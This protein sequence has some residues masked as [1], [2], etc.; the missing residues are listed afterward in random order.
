M[1][2]LVLGTV[3]GLFLFLARDRLEALWSRVSLP[4]S[5]AKAPSL[6]TLAVTSE[7]YE[8]VQIAPCEG[9]ACRAKV[10]E[11]PTSS[12]VLIEQ[13]G[14]TPG[15]ATLLK[16]SR[17]GAVLDK[18]ELEPDTRLGGSGLLFSKETYVDW[19]WT[20]DKTPKPYLEKL[21][22]NALAPEALEP[23]L[24]EA[25]WLDCEVDHDEQT[26]RCF[27][28]EP[29]QKGGGVRLLR[30][31]RHYH[32]L[33]FR[34]DGDFPHY[35][36]RGHESLSEP[37]L[38]Q[39]PAENAPGSPRAGRALLLR[40]LVKQARL[41]PAPMDPTG[42]RDGWYGIGFWDLMHRGERLAFRAPAF[43]SARAERVEPMFDVYVV[44]ATDKEPPLPV[45]V[46]AGGEV[47]GGPPTNLGIW[48]V[49]SRT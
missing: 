36:L 43:G 11:L 20:G 49:R 26:G 29:A 35:V 5:Q 48:T 15:A 9:P 31:Q 18:C 33:T 10:F 30:T 28:G 37:K 40:H 14:L 38:R 47:K 13:T 8:L 17:A 6:G 32:E 34:E 25:A 42:G 12:A 46:G 39:V 19:V 23:L 21:D 24:K 2:W 16:L 3:A 4:D 41:R 1:K 45:L 7:H 44:P 22:G 27:L